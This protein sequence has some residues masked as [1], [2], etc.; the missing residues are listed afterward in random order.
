MR[1]PLPRVITTAWLGTAI[2]IGCCIVGAAP[3]SA[4]SDERQVGSDP[5]ASLWCD[6]PE[7]APAGNAAQTDEARRGLHDG[8]TTA[9]PEFPA[10]AG[11][12]GR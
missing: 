8:L 7:P 2:A 10:V 9:L 6:C 3:S 12:P 11:R 1:I 4:D 5:F